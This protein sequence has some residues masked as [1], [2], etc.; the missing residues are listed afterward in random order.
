M[1][2]TASQVGEFTWINPVAKVDEDL[3]E[4]IEGI[5]KIVDIMGVSPVEKAQLADYQFKLGISKKGGVLASIE[6]RSTLIE[7]IKA[8][9]F[10]DESLNELRKKTVFGKA[11]DMALDIGGVLSFRGMICVL[12]VD[13]L[14]HKK[15]IAE[16]VA[17][18]QNCQQV[19]YEHQRPAGIDLAPFKNLYGRGCRS[20]IGWFKV[21]DVKPLGVDLV[22][23]NQ[24]KTGEQVFLKV[25]PIKGVMRFD[26]KDKLSPRY[27]DPFE[28]LDYV[29]LVTYRLS[30]PPNQSGVLLVFHV[31][32]LNKYHGD[33]DYIIKWNLV[34]LDNNL[35]YEE[36]PVAILDRDAYKMRTKE[37]KSMRVQWKHL[38]VEEATWK[39]EKNMRDKY[40]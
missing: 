25:S 36:E 1:S 17:K 15:D 7:E 21:G 12:R 11:P 6:V 18:C 5:A 4:F 8:K 23:D 14:I 33:G 37:I 2:I 13:D 9:Q 19:K 28:I 29:G 16:F 35:Q 30:L 31:S 39:T 24:D 27:I 32:I 10:E 22:K 20:L 40:P 38:W 34:L 3:K 26:K